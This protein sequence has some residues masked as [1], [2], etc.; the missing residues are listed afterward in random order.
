MP[1]D[2]IIEQ[3]A[4]PV[5][6][7]ETPEDAEL[8]PAEMADV[9]AEFS[10]ASQREP[11]DLAQDLARRAERMAEARV[12]RLLDERRSAWEIA[13]LAAQYTGGNRYGLPIG[14]Y[15][16]TDFLES[17]NASQFE[18]AKKLFGQIT[19][20]GLV[21]FQEIGHGRRMRKQALPE[22]Y[23]SSLQLAIDAGNT[24]ADFFEL[25]GLGDPGQYDLTQFEGGK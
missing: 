17:L 6:P 15:E 18:A 11:H 20:N 23:H 10:D 3:E 25:A 8:S 14:I 9:M 4:Q 7:V 21:E 22:V 1:A 16:L 12:T 24:V 5:E 19:D 2:E 13:N